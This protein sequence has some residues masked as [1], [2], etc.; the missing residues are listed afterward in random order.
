M[1]SVIILPFNDS[2]KVF[3]FTVD[4]ISKVGL[5]IILRIWNQFHSSIQTLAVKLT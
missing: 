3:G 4:E 2:E 5:I 1:S